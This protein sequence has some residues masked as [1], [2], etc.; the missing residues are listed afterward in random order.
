MTINK[1]SIASLSDRAVYLVL[2]WS[3]MGTWKRV[4]TQDTNS[5]VRARKRI[6]KAEAI[7]KIRKLAGRQRRMLRMYALNSLF[8]PGVYVVPLDYIEQ[9]DDKLKEAK[10]EMELLKDELKAEW[11][12]IIAEAKKRL[13]KHFDPN[14]YRSADAAAAAYDL[15]YRYVPIADTPEILKTIA[16]DAYKEDLERSRQETEKELEQ[17]R[18]SLRLTLLGIVENMRQPLTKPDGEKRVFGQRFF[19]RLDNFLGT[20]DSKNLSDDGALKKVVEQLRKVSQG[21]DIGDLKKD[22]DIQAEMNSNLHQI[23]KTMKEMV[24]EDGRMIDLSMVEDEA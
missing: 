5:E 22:A 4:E 15:N 13:G 2:D 19:K 1:K 21:V 18:D 23:T 9:V 6:V 12:A 17:F 3:F 16:A 20:F 8:R 10:A 11:K 24:K 14:D 7:S